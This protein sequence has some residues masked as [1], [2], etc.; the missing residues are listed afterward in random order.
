[1]G[2]EP[3]YRIIKNE[4]LLLLPP[5]TIV[6]LSEFLSGSKNLVGRGA[7]LP[8]PTPTGFF[9][10]EL[11]RT[12]IRRHPFSKQK[13]LLDRLIAPRPGGLMPKVIRGTERSKAVEFQTLSHGTGRFETR[14]IHPSIPRH[15]LIFLSATSFLGQPI[16]RTAF[17][18]EVRMNLYEIRTIRVTTTASVPRIP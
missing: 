5:V 12:I 10:P 4:L 16:D 15:P 17:L 6:W 9:G 8:N 3:G 13:Q 14:S 1:L 2:L 7:T 11:S 18:N